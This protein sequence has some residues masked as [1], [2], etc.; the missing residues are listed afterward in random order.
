MK[1]NISAYAILG[2]NS[3]YGD[4]EM[5]KNVVEK[6]FGNS[7]YD[8]HIM[9][10]S[11]EYK[12]LDKKIKDKETDW[13]MIYRSSSYQGYAKISKDGKVITGAILDNCGIVGVIYIKK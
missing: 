7:E 6:H 11:P 3:P 9:F 2:G 12:E 10:K 8:T 13:E 1:N 4:S 5:R